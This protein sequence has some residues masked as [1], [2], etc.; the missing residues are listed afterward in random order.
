MRK[1]QEE[2]EGGNIRI[3]RMIE[4]AKVGDVRGIKEE[5]KEMEWLWKIQKQKLYVDRLE[6]W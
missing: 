6:D 5:K 2:E 3:R 1:E 4:E